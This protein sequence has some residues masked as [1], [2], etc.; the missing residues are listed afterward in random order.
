MQDPLKALNKSRHGKNIADTPYLSDDLNGASCPRS[1]HA[2]GY[3]P[4]ARYHI[5]ETVRL[6]AENP[7]PGHSPH[8]H[9]TSSIT[10][11]VHASLASVLPA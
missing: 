4:G 1:A 6:D 3:L 9:N 8:T 10:L 11:K 5:L 7:A 2:G